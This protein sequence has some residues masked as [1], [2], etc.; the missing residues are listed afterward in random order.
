MYADSTTW[1]FTSVEQE[2]RVRLAARG[3]NCHKYQLLAEWLGCYKYIYPENRTIVDDLATMST[4][5]DRSH[6]AFL[7]WQYLDVVESTLS[8]LDQRLLC[9]LLRN[10]AN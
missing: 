7:Y 8:P 2:L 9:Q 1:N 4:V 10:K 6:K 5:F 3:L